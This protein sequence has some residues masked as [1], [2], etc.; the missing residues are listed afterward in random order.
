MNKNNSKREL[1][2]FYVPLHFV[3]IKKHFCKIE[4]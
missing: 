3:S 2:T 4:L 1:K